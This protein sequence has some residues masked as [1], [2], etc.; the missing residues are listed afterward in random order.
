VIGVSVG[1]FGSTTF[2]LLTERVNRSLAH[3]LRKILQLQRQTWAAST[4]AEL[5][6][7][8]F[9]KTVTGNILAKVSENDKRCSLFV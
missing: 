4:R 9:R 5:R 3:Q 6:I 7:K 2:V 1:L 8:L